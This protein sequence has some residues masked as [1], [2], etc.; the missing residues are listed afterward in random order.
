MRTLLLTSQL[1]CGFMRYIA[2]MMML[3]WYVFYVLL[4]LHIYLSTDF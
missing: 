1:G 4:L 3:T 2:T